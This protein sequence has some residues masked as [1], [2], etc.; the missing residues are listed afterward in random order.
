MGVVVVVGVYSFLCGWPM[1][2]VVVV[3][4]GMAVRCWDA[5]W[6]TIQKGRF[7]ALCTFRNKHPLLPH[8]SCNTVGQSALEL[9][10]SRGS[11]HV[12]DAT[13]ACAS[14]AVGVCAGAHLVGP[15]DKLH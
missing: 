13:R 2:V 8:A 14:A 7:R 12:P 4:L 10:V 1:G 5:R 15:M 9:T 6:L 11:V 3:V